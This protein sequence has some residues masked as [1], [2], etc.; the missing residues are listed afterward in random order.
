MNHLNPPITFLRDV[1]RK[2]DFHRSKANNISFRSVKVPFSGDITEQSYRGFKMV[3]FTILKN[4]SKSRARRYMSEYHVT[5]S[6]L[7]IGIHLECI[8]HIQNFSKKI[9]DIRI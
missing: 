3:H 7:I 4:A 8:V 2:R 5:S 1:A 6:A 9:V